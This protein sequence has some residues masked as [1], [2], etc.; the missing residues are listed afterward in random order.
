MKFEIGQKLKV[1]NIDPLQD[2]KVAPPLNPDITY[3]ILNIIKDKEGNQHLDVGL[4]SEYNYIRSIETGE[5]LL[6]GDTIHWCHPSRF[7]LIN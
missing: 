1:V 6:N 5:E 2:N 4:V 3:L 7:E